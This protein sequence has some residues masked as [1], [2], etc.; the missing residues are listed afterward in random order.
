MRI[1]SGILKKVF[2]LAPRFSW[3]I[4]SGSMKGVVWIPASANPGQAF[5]K[6]ESDQQDLFL[7]SIRASTVFWDVGAHVGW[8]SLLAAN[9]DGDIEVHSFEPNPRSFEFLQLHKNLNQFEQISLCKFALSNF[10]GTARFSDEA[11]QSSLAT[12]GDVNVE[13]RTAES[14]QQGCASP[15]D[16]IKIDVEGAEIEFLEGAK[17]ILKQHSPKILLSAH[18]YEK[19]DESK[20]FLENLGYSTQLLTSDGERGDYVFYAVKKI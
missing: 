6:Y 12:G 20:A 11:Q 18:G 13:V 2:S 10:N 9:T 4:P 17:N 1:A 16:F 19:R 5:G 15:P 14:Y 3:K 8:Y 7:K